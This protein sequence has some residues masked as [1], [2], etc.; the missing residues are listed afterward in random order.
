MPDKV[1]TV[2]A[3]ANLL[4]VKESFLRSELNAERIIF[5]RK[6]G[7]QHGHI[8][9]TREAIDAYQHTYTK[10]LKQARAVKAQEELDGLDDIELEEPEVVEAKPLPGQLLLPAAPVQNHDQTRILL[11]GMLER[12]I[13][14]AVEV[15]T[16]TLYANNHRLTR[17]NEDIV[18][19][20]EALAERVTIL[21]RRR[22]P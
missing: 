6:T 10:R 12:M 20:Y 1:L 11:E 15:K 16:G 9:I 7:N 19:K 3:A 4:R 13:D 17:E 2:A 5:T 14:K 8:E 18:R 22:Y 21:E